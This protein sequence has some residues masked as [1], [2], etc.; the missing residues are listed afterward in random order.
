MLSEN[1]CQTSKGTVHRHMSNVIS[2]RFGCTDE[3]TLNTI[4][5]KDYEHYQY[6]NMIEMARETLRFSGQ[7]VSGTPQE[8]VG[9]AMTTSDFPKIL[10]D[11]ANKILEKNHLRLTGTFEPWTAPGVLSDFKKASLLRTSPPSD[12]PVVGEDGEYQ[13]LDIKEGEETVSLQTRGGILSISRQAIVNDDLNAISDTF[14]ILTQTAKLTQN[15][16][17]YI[18]LLSN[19]TLSDGRACF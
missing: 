13:H 2:F 5:K 7:P 1:R 10:S 11:A 6:Y 9:R 4:S 17:A 19:P 3:D 16:R 15:R 18:S 8:I 12:L 14:K